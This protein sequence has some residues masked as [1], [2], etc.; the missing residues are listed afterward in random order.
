[1]TVV[2][3]QSYVALP[4]G[5]VGEI[6]VSGPSV[7]RGYWARPAETASTFGA[8]LAGDG[9]Y[10]RTG[11]LGFALD[12]QLFV[13]GR[14]DD[15]IVIRGRNCDPRDIE[16]AVERSHAD[17]RPS[18]GAAFA[19]EVDGEARLVVAQEVERHA[20]DRDL[21]PIG[22]AIRRAVMEELDLAITAIALL[23]PGTLP[24]TSSGKIRRRACRALYEAGEL[25]ALWV[26]GP[27]QASELADEIDHGA[28]I[29]PAPGGSAGAAV[30]LAD[31]RARVGRLLGIVPEQVDPD[32]PLD[33]VGLDS[34]W[35]SDLALQLETTYHLDVDIARFVQ[36]LTLTE[37]AGLVARGG[38]GVAR[39]RNRPADSD[40]QRAPAPSPASGRAKMQFS[41]LYF[42]GNA[43]ELAGD[44]Y[45]LLLESARFADRHGFDALWVP[46]RHFHPFGGLYPSPSVLA[47]ALAMAT[48]RIRL[49]AG[50]VVLPLHDPVRVVE[51]W[52]MVDNLSRGRVDLAFAT[53]WNPNDFVLAPGSY[54]DRV[55]RLFAGIDTVHRLW[56]GETIVVPNGVGQLTEIRVLP[57]PVQPRLNTWITCTGGVERFEQ[58]GAR[59]ANVLTALLFQTL[60]ELA[61]KIARYRA[62]RARHGHDGA[63]HV[64]L[65][66]HTFVGD[67]SEV[68]R[69]LVRGPFTAYLESSVDLWQ[70]GSRNLAELSD[71]GR[72]AVLAFAFERYFQKSALFGTPETC[73]AMVERARAIGVDEIA[74]LI[75]FGVDAQSAMASLHRLNELRRRWA[76]PEPPS[77]G[78]AAERPGPSHHG[79]TVEADDR[80]GGFDLQ[81]VGRRIRP[82]GAAI[83]LVYRCAATRTTVIGR[84]HLGALPSRV[85]FAGTHRSYLDQFAVRAALASSPARSHLHGLL[86]VGG[87]IG[88][89]AA[90][91]RWAPW[92]AALLGIFLIPQRGDPLACLRGLIREAGADRSVLITPQGR[93]SDPSRERADDRGVAFRTGVAL[94]A[95]A[96]DAPVVPYGISGT[97]ALVA[98]SVPPGYRGWAFADIPL[99]IERGPVALAFGAPMRAA[100]GEHPREFTARIQAACLAL[101]QAAL[102]A[103]AASTPDPPPAARRSSGP[104][105]RGPAATYSPA[106]GEPSR[107]S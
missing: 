58:A 3:P 18:S 101:S 100:S 59:G 22:A 51:E 9:P 30:V 103:L 93:H 11:D 73:A 15:L 55:D 89:G 49:R 46:E 47:A 12:D 66:L 90:A 83:D 34:L 75:D 27:A 62:A 80:R 26:G 68:V 19:V 6:W 45:G 67:D 40:R 44:R 31:L 92:V 86:V 38:G 21:A 71:R 95:V 85:V 17:L 64:T 70:H 24:K 50:S 14:L 87:E 79:Q 43:A 4:A 52:A 56:R 54:A 33:L 20:R 77:G 42:A 53:G 82:L 41:L 1:M 48:S 8:A 5:R 98:P 37:L 91:G 16:C 60:D 7:A 106:P 72:A 81:R 36:D 102:N 23:K 97:E 104:E 39:E 84:D 28:A 99:H 35:A 107:R 61:E 57:P 78:P 94:L 32:Q 69:E 63:G 74:C 76:D 10:L 13:M 25:A 88:F 96:L 2:D 105:P 29:E 65:M